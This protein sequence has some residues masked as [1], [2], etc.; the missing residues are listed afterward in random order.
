VHN[1][2]TRI[3]G[4]DTRGELR[5]Q[6]AHRTL[7]QRHFHA[8]RYHTW[9]LFDRCFLNPRICASTCYNSYTHERDDANGASWAPENRGQKRAQDGF[10]P[11]TNGTEQNVFDAQGRSTKINA[12]EGALGVACHKT[13]GFPHSV[14]IP[15]SQCASVDVVPLPLPFCVGRGETTLFS[16][17]NRILSTDECTCA[18]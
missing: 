13:P 6:R 9:H 18:R 4:R 17:E 15:P 14:M 2:W 10:N 11:Q 12:L 3:C 8:P 1:L 5:G 7:C 16:W